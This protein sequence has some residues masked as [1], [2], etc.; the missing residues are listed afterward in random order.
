LKC[1][2]QAGV[3]LPV[4]ARG[5]GGAAAVVLLIAVC[6]AVPAAWWITLRYATSAGIAEHTSKRKRLN[7]QERPV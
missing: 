6:C 5:F 1:D 2:R 4:V 7:L 3:E